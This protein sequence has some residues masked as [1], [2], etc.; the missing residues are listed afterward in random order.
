MTNLTT[1]LKFAARMASKTPWM[2]AAAVLA[3]GAAMAVTVAGFSLVWDAYFVALPFAEADRIVAVR[4][5]ELPDPDDVPPR[6][7]VYREWSAKQ[8]SLDLLAA[9][10]TRFRDVADGQGGLTRYPVAAMTASG[11]D[12]AGV[13]PLRGRTLNVADQ[14]PGAPPV[15]VVGHRVWR[16]LL[17]ADP[18]AV[19]RTL[20]VDGIEREIIGVMPEGFRFPV[21]EDLW[22]P[23]NPDPD[24]AGVVE[25]RWLAVFGRLAQGVSL[26]QAEAELDAIRAGHVAANPGDVAARDRRTTSSPTS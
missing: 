17:G 14:E 23:F 24:A 19:G 9:A 16:S 25:P 8:T 5:I 12:V 20:E 22:V 15:V 2:T 3:L 10:Y 26:Q 7:T 1:D 21:S 11:F 18:T 6:L 13:A 4:D